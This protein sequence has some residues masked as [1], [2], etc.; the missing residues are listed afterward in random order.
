MTNRKKPTT[1]RK[2]VTKTQA[3]K[4]PT[5]HPTAKTLIDRLKRDLLD[6]KDNVTMLMSQRDA[7]LARAQAEADLVE[8][9]IDDLGRCVDM[10]GAAL[11]MS[12]GRTGTPSPQ[13]LSE[14]GNLL[15][16]AGGTDE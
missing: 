3:T 1:N 5:P 10:Y 13:M 7:I 9:Q 12:E 2:A 11:D 14:K 8:A 15:K 4:Q 6:A 16:I